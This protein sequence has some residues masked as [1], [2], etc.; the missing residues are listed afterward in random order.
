VEEAFGGP[1]WH[2][3]GRG[4]TKIDSRRIALDGLRGVGN[5]LLGQWISDGLRDGIVHV[6]RRLSVEEREE[7][8]VPEP[9]DI[10]GTPEEERRIAAVYAEAPHLRGRLA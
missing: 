10:R 8:G 3:S 5:A 9:F 1:V 7:F 6:Q 2:A 4:A